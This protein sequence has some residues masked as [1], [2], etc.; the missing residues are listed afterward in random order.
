MTPEQKKNN[1]R[2]GLILAS[3]AV[4]FFLGFMAKL[5]FFGKG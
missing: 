5:V 2:L 4:V 1:L 3:I